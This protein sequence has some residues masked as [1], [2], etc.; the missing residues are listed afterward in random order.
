MTAHCLTEERKLAGAQYL[1]FSGD[2][3][4]NIWPPDAE[5]TSTTGLDL[6]TELDWLG[7]ATIAVNK[8]EDSVCVYMAFHITVLLG[9]MSFQLGGLE[10][11]MPGFDLTSDPMIRPALEV[12]DMVFVFGQLNLW[13]AQWYHSQHKMGKIQVTKTT[14]DG[15]DQTPGLEAGIIIKQE[16]GTPDPSRTK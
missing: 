6:P 16:W 10:S 8:E 15:E 2:N 4:S 7:P 11:G 12:G 13:L 14:W 3:A 9:L 5:A 1:D